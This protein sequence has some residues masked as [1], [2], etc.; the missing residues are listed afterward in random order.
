MNNFCEKTL[1]SIA[2]D[3]L[4]KNVKISKNG[5]TTLLDLQNHL[6]RERKKSGGLSAHTMLSGKDSKQFMI[7]AHH[8]INSDGNPMDFISQFFK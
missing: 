4:G 5:K 1:P 8:T 3:S 6:E 2:M 7:A